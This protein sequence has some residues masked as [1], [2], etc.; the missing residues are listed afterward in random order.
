MTDAISLPIEV[1]EI[2]LTPS[3]EYPWAMD[4]KAIVKPRNKPHRE[5]IDFTF[6][7]TGKLLSDL[8]GEIASQYLFEERQHDLEIQ[9]RTPPRRRDRRP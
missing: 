3:R 4:V 6:N 9:R 8:V 7:M 5:V 1:L 2:R